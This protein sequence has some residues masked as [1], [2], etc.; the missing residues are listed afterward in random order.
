MGV[1]TEFPYGGGGGGGVFL[2]SFLTPPVFANRG[3]KNPELRASTKEGGI[4]RI[5]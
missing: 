5:L 1:F 2:V 3:G 4:R